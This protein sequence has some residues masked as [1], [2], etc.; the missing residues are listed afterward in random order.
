MKWSFDMNWEKM[1]LIGQTKMLNESVIALENE[2]LLLNEKLD[3]LESELQCS[4]EHFQRKQLYINELET[5]NERMKYLCTAN[6]T[7]SLLQKIEKLEC[8]A[9]FLQIDKILLQKRIETL[10]SELAKVQKE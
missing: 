10:Q 5:E 7:I 2:N 3:G 1:E 4:K 8:K 6:G 9:S